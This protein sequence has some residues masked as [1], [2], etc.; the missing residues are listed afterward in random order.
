[1]E[2]KER[3]SECDDVYISVCRE[4]FSLEI[5]VVKTTWIVSQ[6][7]CMAGALKCLS[8]CACQ[9]HTSV[10]AFVHGKHTQVPQQC[11]C[12]AQSSASAM[13]MSGTHKCL[14]S[15]H[16]RH[17]QCLSSVHG[18]HTQC[19]SSVHGRHTQV[20]QQCAWQAH[21]VPQQCAWQAQSRASAMCMAG[22]LNHSRV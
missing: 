12:Q 4:Q 13:C 9:A 3:E 19:L 5:Y 17:T 7:L 18:R 15:V 20:P 2:C 6:Q 16:G 14:S 10:S 22:K 11:E 8:S 1:L 21:S